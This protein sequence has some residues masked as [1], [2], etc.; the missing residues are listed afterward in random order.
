MN[1]IASRP[2]TMRAV[3]MPSMPLG[4]LVSASCSR[5][6]AKSTRARPK[7]ADVESANTTLSSKFISFWI[8]IMATPRIVQLVVISGK[9]TPSA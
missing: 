3:G 1:A 8:T 4:S 7:P 2:A 5:I 9:N 6:P